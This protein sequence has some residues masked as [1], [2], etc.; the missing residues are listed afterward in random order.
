MKGSLNQLLE[1]SLWDAGQRVYVA[2]LSAM[3]IM[4]LHELGIVH[5]DVKSHNFLFDGE[6]CDLRVVVTD[7]GSSRISFKTCATMTAQG[8]SF[9]T[10]YWC[11]PELLDE[12]VAEAAGSPP[13]HTTAMDVYSFGVTLWEIATGR[14]PFDGLSMKLFFARMCRFTSEP[15]SLHPLVS[16]LGN[17]DVPE[18]YLEVMCDCLR[19]DPK[20]R[21]SMREVVLRLGRVYEKVAL[22]TQRPTVKDIMRQVEE[23]SVQMKAGRA[24]LL[25]MMESLQQEQQV[26]IF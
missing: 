4:A 1:E 11:A 15:G 25:E 6:G 16:Q 12:D 24:E 21:P 10:L 7:L 20:E 26:P 8:Q 13:P 17:V 19:A 22:S 5:R 14:V 23:L 9:T 2:Q 3:S 18:G